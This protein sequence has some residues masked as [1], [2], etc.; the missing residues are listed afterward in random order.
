VRG[1]GEDTGPANRVGKT[2][3]VTHQVQ[4]GLTMASERPV[5]KWKM[6]LAFGGPRGTVLKKATFGE[7][8][9]VNKSARRKVIK[10]GSNLVEQKSE[11]AFGKP[12][13]S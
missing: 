12:T 1:A 3:W 5:A 8:G 7:D 13:R 10:K 6:E 2:F 9:D 4:Q 11:H